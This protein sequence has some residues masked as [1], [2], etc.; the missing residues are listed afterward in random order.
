MLSARAS[1]LPLTASQRTGAA[2]FSAALVVYLG[3]A[4]FC[5][6]A[7]ITIIDE[8]SYFTE[9]E[10]LAA[11]GDLRDPRAYQ[12]GPTWLPFEGARYPLGFPALLAPFT[13]LPW[14][15]PFALNVLLHL[16]GAA[17]FSEVLRRRGLSR[18]WTLLYLAQPGLVLF[19]RTLMADSLAALH[20]V[21]LLWLAELDEPLWLGLLFGLSPL[22]KLSQLIV[23]APLVLATLASAP[24]ERRARV[25]ILAAM[26]A[27]FPLAL[28]IW[29]STWL[30]G[31]PLRLPGG[32]PLSGPLTAL[33]WLPLGLLQLCAAWP[34]LPLGALRARPPEL[35]AA[36]TLTLYLCFYKGLHY[37]GPT[38]AATLLVGSRLHLPAIILLLPGYAALFS[39]LPFRRAA[40]SAL[41][42]ASLLLPAPI[43]RALAQR[44]AE[45][46]LLRS[47]TLAALSPS[48]LH[49]YSPTA[50]KLLVPWPA[51]LELHS[52]LD[53]PL[54]ESELARGRC[55][56]LISPAAEPTTYRGPPGTNAYFDAL[57]SIDPAPPRPA[58]ELVQHLRPP[59]DR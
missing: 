1:V 44:R 54:L 2:I 34:L 38:L 10:V 49:G 5:T 27:I 51:E 15:W 20:T 29:Q 57:L 42:A 55:V 7:G 21:A 32:S 56:E 16:A 9:A 31:S 43:L 59:R 25:T 39:S 46:E 30:Y 33:T 17:L 28:W 8:V 19:S 53:A 18:R 37:L 12:P 47:R 14:P 24:A 13:R 36:T 6:P 4:L 40:L 58:G 50:E 22:L 26:G 41:S 23:A 11:G 48:C 52:A 3:A 35:I 45:L